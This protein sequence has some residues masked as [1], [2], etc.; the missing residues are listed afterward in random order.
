VPW[1]QLG[2]VFVESNRQQADHIMIKLRGIGCYSSP[3]KN[4]PPYRF[5][6]KSEIELL[7]R[8]EHARWIAERR[9]AGWMFAP[10][11]K[12]AK[13]EKHKTS[14]YL[15]GWDQLDEK[16]RDYDRDAVLDI[17]RLLELINEKI[18]R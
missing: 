8:M 4:E 2:A 18:Y 1:N 11:E 16:V 14:P 17:P 13:D 5:S 12:D 15:V 3:P 6:E 7:A 9:L 10:G